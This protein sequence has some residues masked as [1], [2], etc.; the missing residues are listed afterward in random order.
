MEQWWRWGW[1]SK[2]LRQRGVSHYDIMES[3]SG[4]GRPF[5]DRIQGGLI[6]EELKR[7]LNR[8]SHPRGGLPAGSQGHPQSQVQFLGPA[9]GPWGASREYSPYPQPPR[10]PGAHHHTAR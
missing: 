7:P 4:Q 1:G 10:S 6:K 5:L 9:L 3:S 8:Q 2:A